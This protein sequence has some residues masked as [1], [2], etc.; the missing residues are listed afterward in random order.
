MSSLQRYDRD[1]YVYLISNNS[2][3]LFPQNV[4][5]HFSNQLQMALDF[6]SNTG[7]WEVGLSELEIPHR[8]YN[9]V[10]GNDMFYITFPHPNQE[11]EGRA[12]RS[13]TA[14]DGGGGGDV[15]RIKRE[16]LQTEM[17]AIPLF[18]LE[19]Q[20]VTRFF[21]DLTKAVQEYAPTM[22]LRYVSDSSEHGEL[23]IIDEK[24]TR[25]V[26]PRRFVKLLTGMGMPV[27]ILSRMFTI[28]YPLE[29]G[30]KFYAPVRFT[31]RYT[32][33]VTMAP[34][35]FPFY[36]LRS[37][38]R[39][40]LTPDPSHQPLPKRPKY[41]QVFE[42]K[43]TFSLPSGSKY[44]DAAMLFDELY[45]EIDRIHRTED[46]VEKSR[47][48]DLKVTID[49]HTQVMSFRSKLFTRIT[50]GEEAQ[51]LLE[52]M[53]LPEY[54]RKGFV[55][56]D[57]DLSVP[58]NVGKEQLEK[59]V[60]L[61]KEF[62]LSREEFKDFDFDK[63]SDDSATTYVLHEELTPP[64]TTTTET[65]SPIPPKAVSEA[66]KP[67]STSTGLR[68]PLEDYETTALSTP[69]GPGIVVGQFQVPAG[70]HANAAAILQEWNSAVDNVSAIDPERAGKLH[71]SF[72]KDHKHLVVQDVPGTRITFTHSTQPFFD[73]IG[74]PQNGYR[75]DAGFIIPES[76]RVE[77]KLDQRHPH[78]FVHPHLS[79]HPMVVVRSTAPVEGHAFVGHYV[80]PPASS[81]PPS[82][83]TVTKT[84]TNLLTKILPGEHH[85]V[86]VASGR[87]W[88]DQLLSRQRPGL[89][90]HGGGDLH[91][92]EAVSKEDLVMSSP[93]RDRDPP[94]KPKVVKFH[95]YHGH[96][97]TPQQLF[98]E[99]IGMIERYDPV[100]LKDVYKMS[101]YPDGR[102]K[103]TIRDN[104]HFIR[105]DNGLLGMLGIDPKAQGIW[106]GKDA[107]HAGLQPIDMCGGANFFLVHSDIVDMT[108]VGNRTSRILRCVSTASGDTVN[109]AD[110][111]VMHF[112][113]VYYVP[114][115]K[116]FIDTISIAIYNDYGGLVHFTPRGKTLLVLHFRRRHER[117]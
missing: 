83:N 10:D 12:K 101:T 8:F 104:N 17:V 5:S 19:W 29:S 39:P 15:K 106:L 28:R 116:K 51:V 54:Y 81:P 7:D 85:Q 45:R 89:I 84:L 92:S 20:N 23:F 111:V 2:E 40:S 108:R 64:T 25:V 14:A 42:H 93:L 94:V 6:G 26:F 22:E 32:G 35:N 16:T 87:P 88:P 86:A 18:E 62:T 46:D 3:Q 82:T 48:G 52:E 73:F 43:R 49:L 102:L 99:M 36:I 96:Y 76:G 79:T 50:F 113:N 63:P 24:D 95:L 61:D 115:A 100:N 60:V 47:T 110:T 4:A 59:E 66:A 9:I 38:P 117:V 103:L 30:N 31:K 72:D 69:A 70:E 80:P 74:V 71:L 33:K 65:A 97:S 1:F 27:N 21:V 105:F 98:D 91:W 78:N 75:T 114:V 107:K 34:G 44:S 13:A 56:S 68:I 57:T 37:F 109:H 11:E 53:G 41:K 112:P 77:I 90:E 55:M 67:L 58:L